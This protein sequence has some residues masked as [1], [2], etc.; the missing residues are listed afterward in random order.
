MF[1][2]ADM[3]YNTEHPHPPPPSHSHTLSVNT[4]YLGWGG[5]GEVREKIEGQ[6]ALR[7]NKQLVKSQK[8]HTK[9]ATS[10]SRNFQE[11]S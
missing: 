11:K 1:T 7:I 8:I 2:P 10:A 4:A 9:K 6:Q 5:G 3:V